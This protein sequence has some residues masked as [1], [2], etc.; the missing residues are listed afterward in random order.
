MVDTWALVNHDKH[1]LHAW[2]N[3][4]RPRP[5]NKVELRLKIIN[6][7]TGANINHLIPLSVNISD[8]LDETV[9]YFYNDQVWTL[10][11]QLKDE[12]DQLSNLNRTRT[13]TIACFF[14]KIYYT[15][16][17]AGE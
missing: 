11:T 16:L 10:D 6:I 9:N 8:L 3:A 2:I 4:L 13:I 17:H 5:K 12:N 1:T 14:V 15:D 7:I